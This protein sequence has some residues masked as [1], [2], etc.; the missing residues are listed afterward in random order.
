MTSTVL[1]L[2]AMAVWL[3]GLASLLTL[4]YRA[5]VPSRVV[6]RFSRWRASR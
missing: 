4:F 3:G 2:L 1:H 5:S 6:G